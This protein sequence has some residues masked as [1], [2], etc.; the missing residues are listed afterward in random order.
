M[1]IGILTF[2]RAWNY[3]A[4][5]QCYA[6]QEVL[7]SMGYDVWVIDYFDPWS[8]K[9]YQ[10]IDFGYLKKNIS[11]P[12]AWYY[13]LKGSMDRKRRKV[14]FVKFVKDHIHLTDSCQLNSIPQNFDRYIVGSDQMWSHSCLGGKEDPVY[15]G[16]FKHSPESKILTYAVS[17]N[18]ESLLKMGSEKLK[19]YAKNFSSL[20]FREESFAE[21]FAEL[22][23]FKPHVDLDPTLLTENST[24]LPL[25][26]NKWKNRKYLVTY[27]VAGRGGK[28]DA[29]RR[30]A[31]NIAKEKSLEYIDLSDMTY[32]VSNF[33]SIIKYAQGVITSSFHATVFSLIFHTPFWA[34]KI[35]DGHD[36]RY[37]NLLK[38]VDAEDSLIDVNDDFT[39]PRSIDYT[40]ISSNMLKLRERS[41]N[42]L[43]GAIR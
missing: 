16:T 31:K 38:T 15:M 24:W 29:L 35:N 43:R 25:L 20:S 21:L 12:K 30:K 42:Y 36:G 2:H 27:Q 37:V 34:V 40:A 11:H 13:Y 32:S 7:K 10:V 3:G 8:A 5:L 26:N 9:V 18:K 23:G 14:V 41:L 1:K 19:T 17:T 4:V 22:T 33:L 39:M 6:L 28:N